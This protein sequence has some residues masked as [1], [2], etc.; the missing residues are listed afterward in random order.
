MTLFSEDVSIAAARRAP[1][2]SRRGETV[3]TKDS[4]RIHDEGRSTARA[5]RFEHCSSTLQG[6]ALYLARDAPPPPARRLGRLPRARVLP[7]RSPPSR[8]RASAASSTRAR[9]WASRR[10]RRLDALAAHGL[11]RDPRRA[12][13]PRRQPH[14]RCRPRPRLA[15][16]ARA[17]VEQSRRGL[18]AQH[19]AIA[20]VAPGPRDGVL[21]DA[22]GVG[23]AAELRQL[24]LPCGPRAPASAR[25]SCSRSRRAPRRSPRRAPPSTPSSRAYSLEPPAGADEP[26]PDA[27]DAGPRARP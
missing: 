5:A 19:L 24:Y 11:S 4:R 13:P 27:P 23:R 8:P 16:D 26:R 21:V 20:R 9:A 25:P 22:R 14:L 17:L 12:A 3:G 1:A 2:T 15:S 7:S 18:E 10:A 6:R